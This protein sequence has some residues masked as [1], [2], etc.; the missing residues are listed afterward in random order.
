MLPRR[1]SANRAGQKAAAKAPADA[2][3]VGKVLEFV[4]DSRLYT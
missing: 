3:G 1:G 2:T 4:R